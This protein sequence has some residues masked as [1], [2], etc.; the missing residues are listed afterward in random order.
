MSNFCSLND[1]I[2]N[3][4]NIFNS[5]KLWIGKDLSFDS[6]EY[7]IISYELPQLVETNDCY[8]NF[9]CKIVIQETQVDIDGE[10]FPED[11]LIIEKN[12]YFLN[13][14]GD[15]LWSDSL[16]KKVWK[17]NYPTTLAIDLDIGDIYY[18][19]ESYPSQNEPYFAQ[20]RENIEDKNIEELYCKRPFSLHIDEEIMMAIIDGDEGY[21]SARE[22]IEIKL[23]WKK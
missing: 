1:A 13:S 17:G 5:G 10:L 8:A 3:L 7:D 22:N 6:E 2:I 21:K 9:K 14:Y 18:F 12:F 16:K 4:K 11:P 20:T 15:F 23:N 19:Y